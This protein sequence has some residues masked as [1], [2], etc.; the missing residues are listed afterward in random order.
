MDIDG[1]LSLG[2]MLYQHAACL[3]IEIVPDQ[4]VIQQKFAQRRVDRIASKIQSLGRKATRELVGLRVNIGDGQR[5]IVDQ[6]H[7]IAALAASG[8]SMTAEQ[9]ILAKSQT[10]QRFRKSRLVKLLNDQK[11]A[12]DVD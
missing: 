7:V 4:Y 3:K 2:D 6:S 8:T 11:K 1:S 10:L 9:D 12:A 5:E